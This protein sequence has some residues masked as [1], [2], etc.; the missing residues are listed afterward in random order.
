MSSTYR[1]K[2]RSKPTQVTI[3]YSA[4]NQQTSAPCID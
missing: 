1:L 4:R 3:H 2:Y